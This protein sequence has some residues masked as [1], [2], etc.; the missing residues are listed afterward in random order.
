MVCGCSKGWLI[1]LRAYFSKML[2]NLGIN[3]YFTGYPLAMRM[4]YCKAGACVGDTVLW[5]TSTGA[6]KLAACIT[7]VC[8]MCR[9]GHC[10]KR[11]GR[12]WRPK[13]VY[14]SDDNV[15]TCG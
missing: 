1:N 11:L 6:K 13:V 5:E 7:V 8:W 3:L 15:C 2:L 9:T 12:I 10:M 4:E 14:S